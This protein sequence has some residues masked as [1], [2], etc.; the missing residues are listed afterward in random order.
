MIGATGR[1]FNYPSAFGSPVFNPFAIDR[2]AA[3]SDT[4]R[5]LTPSLPSSPSSSSSSQASSS[6]SARVF[7]NGVAFTPAKTR[8]RRAHQPRLSSTHQNRA[9]STRHSAAGNHELFARISH[10]GACVG[11]VREEYTKDLRILQIHYD[12]A[13][14]DIQTQILDMSRALFSDDSVRSMNQATEIQQK[15]EVAAA[16]ATS[17]PSP[18]T[19]GHQFFIPVTQTRDVR[20]ILRE[21]QKQ[22]K[23]LQDLLTA[24]AEDDHLRS[25]AQMLRDPRLTRRRSVK[26]R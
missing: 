8:P 1:L 9:G 21:L 25:T 3:E 16:A 24:E 15:R 14:L 18:A 5:T 6:S 22:Q 12:R 13:L 10:L 23:P 19:M 20:G 4:P 26:K 17:L 11:A 7:S 2:S